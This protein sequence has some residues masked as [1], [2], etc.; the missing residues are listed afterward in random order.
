MRRI[1]REEN[2]RLRVLVVY[3]IS[4]NY[5]YSICCYNVNGG[6]FRDVLGLFGGS[7]PN[8]QGVSV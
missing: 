1:V 3:L 7:S 2:M 4:S 6:I 5:L 8:I